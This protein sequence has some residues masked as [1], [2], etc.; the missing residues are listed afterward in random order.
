MFSFSVYSASERGALFSV[1]T[2]ARRVSN[3]IILVVAFS[4]YEV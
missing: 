1:S 2:D 4:V 3:G